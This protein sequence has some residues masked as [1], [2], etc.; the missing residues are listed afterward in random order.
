MPRYRMRS[1]GNAVCA[2]PASTCQRSAGSSRS[3]TASALSSR[4]KP[5]PPDAEVIVEALDCRHQRHRTW[6]QPQPR[7]AEDARQGAPGMQRIAG[8]RTEAMA[9]VPWR[10]ERKVGDDQ[11]VSSRAR[12]PHAAQEACRRA[13]DIVRAAETG[14][15]CLLLDPVQRRPSSGPQQRGAVAM[16]FFDVGEIADFKNA[17]FRS[18]HKNPPPFAP[19]WPPTNGRRQGTCREL[20]GLAPPH[21]RKPRAL[22]RCYF[23]APTPASRRISP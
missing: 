1:V 2:D 5:W 23:V 18:E 14:R 4:K 20:P 8:E 16:G 11:I 19:P 6:H 15:R 13:I 9:W 22:F 7:H 12:V 21:N 10:V 3:N 17:G